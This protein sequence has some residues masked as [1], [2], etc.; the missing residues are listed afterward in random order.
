MYDM[1]PTAVPKGQP[2]TVSIGLLVEL[3][4]FMN[5]QDAKVY[6]HDDEPLVGMAKWVYMYKHLLVH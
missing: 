3:V 4:V 5:I 1:E 2:V 6:L